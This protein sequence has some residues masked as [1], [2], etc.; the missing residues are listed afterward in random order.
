MIRLIFSARFRCSPAALEREF[1]V[2]NLF[3]DVQ[4]AIHWVALAVVLLATG[5]V[6]LSLWIDRQRPRSLKVS[7]DESYIADDEV[8]WTDLMKTLE[9]P[10]A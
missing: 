8:S 5:L 7:V 6:S 3:V 10:A 4:Y 2:A 9:G 1:I